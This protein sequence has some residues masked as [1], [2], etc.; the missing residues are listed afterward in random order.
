[1]R[2]V[3]MLEI[4]KGMKLAFSQLQFYILWLFKFLYKC[5]FQMVLQLAITLF[6]F[7]AP[8]SYHHVI[9]NIMLLH[10][11]PTLTFILLDNKAQ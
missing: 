10:T 4:K 1:M 6:H 7:V 3:C 8:I 9:N 2:W 5:N 11:V